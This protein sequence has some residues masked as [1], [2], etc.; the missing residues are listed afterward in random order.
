MER[1]KIVNM[2][3]IHSKQTEVWLTHALNE[4]LM[5]K[6]FK[7]ESGLMLNATKKFN[8]YL[9][10]I[11]VTPDDDPQHADETIYEESA[12]YSDIIKDLMYMSEPDI[13]R[14]QGIIKKIN[15]QKR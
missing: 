7:Y 6:E 12:K 8:K 4:G 3:V 2:V 9:L 14:V 13:K 5:N 1:L 11:A 15:Q 10:K